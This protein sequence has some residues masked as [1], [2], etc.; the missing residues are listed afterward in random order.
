MTQG[1][2][3]SDTEGMTEAD[4]GRMATPGNARDCGR[5]AIKAERE[6]RTDPPQALRRHQPGWHLDFGLLAS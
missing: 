3:D 5:A 1:R 4:M 2:R 6:A